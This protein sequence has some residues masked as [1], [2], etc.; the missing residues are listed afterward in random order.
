MKNT[1]SFT[2]FPFPPVRLPT[3]DTGGCRRYISRV[4]AVTEQYQTPGRFTRGT[5]QFVE[6]AVDTSQY[7][8]LPQELKQ[9]LGS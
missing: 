2:G 4:H 3:D 7:L 8:D 9:R 1:T 5:I 6:V